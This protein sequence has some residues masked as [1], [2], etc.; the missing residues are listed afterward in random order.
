ME[1]AILELQGDEDRA[2]AFPQTNAR[3]GRA[4]R[5]FFVVVAFQIEDPIPCRI[6]TTCSRMTTQGRVR[7]DVLERAYFIALAKPP[8]AW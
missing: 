5:A 6:Q 4:R 3:P 1:Q 8:N 7:Y 2:A